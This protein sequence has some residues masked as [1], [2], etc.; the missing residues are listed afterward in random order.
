M[1]RSVVDLIFGIAFVALT[2]GCA[3]SMNIQS[4]KGEPEPM[5]REDE[6]EMQEMLNPGPNQ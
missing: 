4:S 6:V 2:S 3:S 1:K 5:Q